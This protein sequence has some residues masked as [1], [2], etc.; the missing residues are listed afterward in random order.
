MVGE[1]ER[2]ERGKRVREESERKERESL[3]DQRRGLLENHNHIAALV[4]HLLC[5][6]YLRALRENINN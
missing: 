4:S 1:S 6:T 3:W 5:L 2:R